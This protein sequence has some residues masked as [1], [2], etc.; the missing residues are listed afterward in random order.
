MVLPIGIPWVGVVAC[1]VKPTHALSPA[2]HWL[3]RQFDRS[4]WYTLGW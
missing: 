3:T 1:A 4:T 2:L